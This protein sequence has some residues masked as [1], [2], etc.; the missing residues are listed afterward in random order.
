MRTKNRSDRHLLL[1]VPCVRTHMD[2][3]TE[4]QCDETH[5]ILSSRGM[6]ETLLHRVKNVLKLPFSSLRRGLSNVILRNGLAGLQCK[7]IHP[8]LY[9]AIKFGHVRIF[10][11]K[12]MLKCLLCYF[13]RAE[14]LQKYNLFWCKCTHCR[15]DIVLSHFPWVPSSSHQPNHRDDL[16]GNSLAVRPI[17]LFIFLQPSLPLPLLILLCSPAPSDLYDEDNRHS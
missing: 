1:I 8:T 2:I 16:E 4:W 3:N 10:H 9:N 11:W 15:Q 5:H 12:I 6:T 14:G 7:V 17:S 13:K